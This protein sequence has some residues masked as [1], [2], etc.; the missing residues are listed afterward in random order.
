MVVSVLASTVM[1]GVVVVVVVVREEEDFL[2]CI[3]SW[4]PTWPSYWLSSSSVAY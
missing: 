3:T 4:I 1:K 2:K